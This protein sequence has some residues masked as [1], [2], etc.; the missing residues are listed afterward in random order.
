MS[1]TN[2]EYFIKWSRWYWYTIFLVLLNIVFPILFEVLFIIEESS[3]TLFVPLFSVLLIVLT[4]RFIKSTLKREQG[5]SSAM[6]IIISILYF[7]YFILIFYGILEIS[8]FYEW[9]DF[10]TVSIIMPFGLGPFLLLIN[11]IISHMCHKKGV[12][13]ANEKDWKLTLL[14]IMSIIIS[15]FLPVIIITIII[16]VVIFLLLGNP[17]IG[18]KNIEKSTTKK[19]CK[20]CGALIEDDSKFCVNCGRKI[21]K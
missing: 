3:V 8:E 19:Y 12:I 13:L 1:L 11:F 2:K 6:L 5:F 18:K 16:G 4:I 9:K 10:I 21:S 17:S 14:G 20:N 15:I 7:I